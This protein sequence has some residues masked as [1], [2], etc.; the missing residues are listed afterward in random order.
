MY[1][2]QKDFKDK[3]LTI[4]KNG[5]AIAKTFLINQTKKDGP[6]HFETTGDIYGIGLGPK[7]CI[8]KNR[9]FNQ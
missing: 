6:H 7:Y 3:R 1:K 9:T 2:F 8:D 4:I 5:V